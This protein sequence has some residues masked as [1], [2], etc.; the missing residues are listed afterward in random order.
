MGLLGLKQ[1]LVQFW[2]IKI[3]LKD[4]RREEKRKKGIKV[5]NT[6]RTSRFGSGFQRG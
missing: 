3:T 1:S 2:K 5:K 4:W 6:P